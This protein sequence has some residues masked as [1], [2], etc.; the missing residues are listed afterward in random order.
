LEASAYDGL[1]CNPGAKCLRTNKYKGKKYP[2]DNNAYH[3]SLLKPSDTPSSCELQRPISIRYSAAFTMAASISEKKNME[4]LNAQWDSDGMAEKYARAEAVTKPYADIMM[5]KAGVSAFT[6]DE[7][8]LDVATG[9][10]AVLAALYEAVFQ[11]KRDA[12]KVIAGD[13][14]DSMLAYVEK[15]KAR[16]GWTGVETR[17]IDGV[18]SISPV[19]PK[20]VVP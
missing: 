10:G 16:E 3:R 1:K 11:E 20:F 14:S 13:I 5:Q 9:T 17:K 19:S 12:L 2:S 4:A 7:Q 8:I 15:R 6:G 18:V